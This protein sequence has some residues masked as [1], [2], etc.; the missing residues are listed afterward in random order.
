MRFFIDYLRQDIR[1]AE[2]LRRELEVNDVFYWQPEPGNSQGGETQKRARFAWEFESEFDN[3]KIVYP[4]PKN[5]F[6]STPLINNLHQK[7]C[8][9]SEDPDPDFR[10]RKTV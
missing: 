5:S 3:K 7:V 10:I 4:N 9:G 1:K 6:G 8:L 2:K